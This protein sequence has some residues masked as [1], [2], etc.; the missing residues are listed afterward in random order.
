MCIRD[1]HGIAL[2]EFERELVGIGPRAALKH[3]G[4]RELVGHARATVSYT[5][6][7]VYKRQET[8]TSA[9]TAGYARFPALI[10]H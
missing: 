10:V 8:G 3:L 9:T 6:L 7:D 2:D 4:S 1:S 5:H